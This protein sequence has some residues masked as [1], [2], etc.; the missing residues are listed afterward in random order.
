MQAVGN[1]HGG[2]LFEFGLLVLKLGEL[3]RVWP[4][5]EGDLGKALTSNSLGETV[6]GYQELFRSILSSL[7]PP[8]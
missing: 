7:G 8:R 3:K 2:R 4:P 5:L 1:W 6:R